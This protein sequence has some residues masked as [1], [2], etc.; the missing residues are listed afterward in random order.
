MSP[1]GNN[2]DTLL[3]SSRE[4]LSKGK[5][6]RKSRHLASVS[7]HLRSRPQSRHAF[8]SIQANTFG[9]I[10]E[11]IAHNLYFLVLQAI[12]WNQTSGMQAR[13]VFYAMVERYPDPKH[14]AKASL[15][16]LTAL[17]RPLG[18][19]NTRAR[20]CI[21]LAVRWN[22]DPPTAKQTYLRKGYPAQS[23]PTDKGEGYEIAHLPGVGPYALDSFRIF[24]RDEMRGL[25]GDWLGTGAT[26]EGFE[27]EWKHVLPLDKELR[28]YLKWRWLKEGVS[29]DDENGH[30]N[31]SPS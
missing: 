15:A 4:A 7:R 16:E 31:R 29:W 6:P 19:H 25:A 11:T 13:P 20:R 18:L 24:H 9:I 17:L 10:Q 21:A 1:P 14:L 12:L 3:V 26:V 8:P 27:P 5:A 23:L 28:A 22:E 30:C 2:K